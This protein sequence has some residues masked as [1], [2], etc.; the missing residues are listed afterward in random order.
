[1]NKKLKDALFC[2]RRQFTLVWKIKA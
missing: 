1:M 2:Q